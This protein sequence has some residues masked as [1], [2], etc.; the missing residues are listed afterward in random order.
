MVAGS[1]PPPRK[2]IPNAIKQEK[3]A[4]NCGIVLS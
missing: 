4:A 3:L 1:V 2:V